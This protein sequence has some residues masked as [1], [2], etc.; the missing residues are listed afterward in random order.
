[1][2]KIQSSEKGISFLAIVMILAVAGFFLLFALR[3]FPLYN[4]KF[5]V[6]T[7]MDNI[8]TRPGA[9]SLPV[10]E[11]R[12]IFLK[13]MEIANSTRFTDKTVKQYVNL[14]KKKKQRFLHVS[15]EAKNVF[16]KDIGL[17]LTFDRTVELGAAA[18]SDE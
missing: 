16:I 9:K 13:N 14:V 17:V 18:P 4:E 8:A 1:M 2:K 11:L 7:T 10:R 15:Y 5:V 3:L 12:K 6:N